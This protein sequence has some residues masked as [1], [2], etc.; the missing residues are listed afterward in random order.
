MIVTDSTDVTTYFDGNVNTNRAESTYIQNASVNAGTETTLNALMTGWTTAFRGATGL[1]KYRAT[2]SATDRN[3][4]DAIAEKGYSV[5]DFGAVGNGVADDT[6]ACQ[7][8]ITAAQAA[9]GGTVVFPD[10]TY[11]T[12][13]ALTIAGTAV[14]LAGQGQPRSQILGT[15]AAQNGITVSVGGVG[16]S[17]LYIKHA[18]SSGT[19]VSLPNSLSCLLS[20]VWVSGYATNVS[21]YSGALVNVDIGTSAVGA[22]GLSVP[23]VGYATGVGVTMLGGSIYA[24]ST[25]ASVASG[26]YLAMIGTRMAGS[27]GIDV[28]STANLSASAVVHLGGSYGLQTATD[29]NI[30]QH[31]GCY[32]GASGNVNDRRTGAPVAYSFS[33]NSSVVPLVTSTDVIRIIATSAITVTVFAPLPP[34]FGRGFKLMCINNSGGAVTWVFS[35][36]YKLVG[37]AAPAP[38]TGN[39]TLIA[40]EYDPVSAVYREVTR[41]TAAI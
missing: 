32:W 21:M 40:F 12:S 17:G 18:G 27:L 20:S 1:W 10:G 24:S 35:A 16:I 4:A 22:T 28:G 36:T 37:G 39:C 29:S 31:V 19:G 7:A 14:N 38:A 30:V 26:G 9:G 8:A 23:A 6:T 25:C 5:K 2:A 15:G 13:S 34:G 3:P 41:S 11:L 33:T